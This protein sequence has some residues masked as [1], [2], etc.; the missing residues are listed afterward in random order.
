MK[1]TY[2]IELFEEYE[3][4]NF[5]SIRFEGDNYTEVEKFLSK[6]P[7]GSE[8]DKDIDTILVWLENISK[9]GALERYFRPEGKYGDGVGTVPISIGNRVRLY[10]LRLSDS[11]LILGNGGVKEVDAWQSSSSLSSYVKLLID[12]SRFIQHRKQNKQI[13]FSNRDKELKGNLKFTRDE[14][15]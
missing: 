10:C 5:Y 9:R 2:T 4:V 7:K 11:M 6:F 15:E 13:V 14:K 12:T 3:T 8:F 1:R